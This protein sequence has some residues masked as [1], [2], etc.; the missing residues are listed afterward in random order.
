MINYTHIEN[1]MVLG[2]Y[3]ETTAVEGAIDIC[4]SLCNKAKPVN[5]VMSEKWSDEEL[6]KRI[7]QYLS[8]GRVF[9]S[10]CLDDIEGTLSKQALR[11][12]HV[13]WELSLTSKKDAIDLY[14]EGEEYE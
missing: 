12:C 8:P 11:D 3:P 5:F 9:C 14:Y 4:C 13:L 7:N 10:N 1:H 2:D 6:W